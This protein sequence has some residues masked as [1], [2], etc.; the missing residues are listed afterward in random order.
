MS[1]DFLENVIHFA[2]KQW[3]STGLVPIV[4]V[5]EM[6]V[7]IL[8]CFFINSDTLFSTN[9]VQSKSNAHINYPR[10]VFTRNASFEQ[11]KNMSPNRPNMPLPLFSFN[12]RYI[13]RHS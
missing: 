4:H 1:K 10:V 8:L 5:F 6:S 7:N 13:L 11:S 12:I 9:S 2:R 3:P